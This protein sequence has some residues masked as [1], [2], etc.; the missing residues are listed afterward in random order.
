MLVTEIVTS[1]ILEVNNAEK[2][3]SHFIGIRCGW[4]DDSRQWQSHIFSTK[5]LLKIEEDD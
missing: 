1:R 2:V 3:K 5:D 4:F